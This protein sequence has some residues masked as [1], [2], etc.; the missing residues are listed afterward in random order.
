MKY[1]LCVLPPVLYIIVYHVLLELQAQTF[2]PLPMGVEI[3]LVGI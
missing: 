1:Q 2:I 3:P